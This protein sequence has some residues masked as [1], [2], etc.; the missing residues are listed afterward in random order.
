MEARIQKR[1]ALIRFNF[2]VSSASKDWKL[3]LNLLLSILF[4]GMGVIFK[5]KFDLGVVIY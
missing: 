4:V 1:E 5:L 3:F 2:Q